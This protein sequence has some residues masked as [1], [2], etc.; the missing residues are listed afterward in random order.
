VLSVRRV[1][2]GFCVLLLTFA[3]AAPAVAACAGWSMAPGDRHACCARLGELASTGSVTDCCA[4]AEQSNG[5]G[6]REHQLP[7]SIRPCFVSAWPPAPPPDASAPLVDHAS[8]QPA[9]P[10]KYI[11][12]GA[13]LI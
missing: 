4:G 11:L 6:D 7:S 12:L 10:P 13:F 9:S 8:V 2:A 3:A 1:V 5:L